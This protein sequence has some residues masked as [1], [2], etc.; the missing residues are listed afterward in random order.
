MG[1]IGETVLKRSLF[2]A[3]VLV[4]A[5]ACGKSQNPDSQ[6]RPDLQSAA[7]ESVNARENGAA[8]AGDPQSESDETPHPSAPKSPRNVLRFAPAAIIDSTG[9]EQPIAAATMLIPYG[10]KTEGGVYWA[11]EFLCTNGYNFVWSATSPDGLTAL[12]ITPQTAWEYS[13]YGAQASR[14]GCQTMQMGSVRQYL[15]ASVQQSMPGARVL[16]FHERPDLIEGAQSSRTPMPMGEIQIWSEAGEILFAFNKNGRDMRGSMAAVVQFQKTVT[17]MTSMYQSDPTIA[18]MPSAAQTRM[19]AVSAFAY[20]GFASSAPE[21]QLNLALMEALRKTIAPNPTW[22]KRIANHNAAIGRVALEESKKRSRMIAEANDYT[23]RLI[24]ET[25]SQRQESVD[26]QMR[27]FGEAIK[28]VETYRDA[29]A[30]SG[31]VELSHA[32]DHAWRLNDGSYILSN[33]ANFDPWKDLQLE[34]RRLE[35]AR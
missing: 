21:G 16:E 29:D 9:F 22:S 18:A 1:E 33:D 20:P 4:A 5:A 11:R 15:E 35:A 32:Y 26:R 23:S 30:P 34:G 14:P 8:P 3:A 12:G 27:E 17:D 28:G 6:T 7:A 24:Q 31:E 13:S 19:E 2:A 25:W 10:W